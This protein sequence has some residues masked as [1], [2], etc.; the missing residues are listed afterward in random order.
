DNINKQFNQELKNR[1]N[2]FIIILSIFFVVN[3]IVFIFLFKVR[4]N[5][6]KLENELIESNKALEKHKEDL[7][8]EVYQRTEELEE[9]NEELQ[10]SIN[11]LN[12]TQKHMVEQEKMAA[13]GG[14]VA[15]VAHEIN[16]PV[17]LG[18]TGI[19]HFIDKTQK[20]KKSYEKEEMSEDDFQ[21]YLKESNDLAEIIYTNLKRSADLVKSFKEIS[22][23]Q[24]NEVK[25][26]FNFKEYLE[27]ILLSI[28]SKT[29]NKHMDINLD[30]SDLIVIS[31]YPGVYAQ[32]ITNLIMNSMIHG[33]ENKNDGKIDITVTYMKDD[34][35]I[36]YKDN[37]KGIDKENIKK[38]F[39]PFF[40][41]KR[42]EGG[43]GLGLNIIYNLITS[44][45][46]GTIECKSEIGKST[47]F[48]IKI[49][50]KDK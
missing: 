35:S 38:I 29:K 34:L 32:I 36:V 4:K 22:V 42:D 10:V 26:E 3:I 27:K 50:L 14:L 19:T 28:H 6:L 45:L 13:L 8:Y 21:K 15:G 11:N 1:D 16:T 30:C 9:S 18:I 49:P 5:R 41:T 44:R 31:S 20:L 48:N 17:G 2:Y 25:K 23:D 46:N 12:Q 24:T 47:Q 39:N 43:S 37:G 40:T 7:E 33:F